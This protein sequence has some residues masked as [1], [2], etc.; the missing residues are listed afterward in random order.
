MNFSFEE[1]NLQSTFVFNEFQDRFWNDYGAYISDDDV[2]KFLNNSLRLK[3]AVKKAGIVSVNLKKGD[4]SKTLLFKKGSG[5]AND[6]NLLDTDMTVKRFGAIMAVKALQINRQKKKDFL[7]SPVGIALGIPA[8]KI[9]WHLAAHPG[10]Y[11]AVDE[12]KYYPYLI[13]LHKAKKSETKDYLAPAAR[14]QFEGTTVIEYVM[15]RRSAIVQEFE[16]ESKTWKGKAAG[17]K[18]GGLIDECLKAFKISI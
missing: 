18:I 6:R 10:A 17:G 11:M 9:H 16:D 1:S 8:E 2:Q 4:K 7:T 14:Q 5:Q 15:S 12:F 3:E 13:E